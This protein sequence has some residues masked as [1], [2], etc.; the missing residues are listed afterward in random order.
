[1]ARIENNR[2]LHPTKRVIETWKSD[3]R[4]S[5]G[6]NTSTFISL[7][8]LGIPYDSHYRSRIVLPAG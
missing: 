1:M 4:T 5:D 7:L 8:D 2:L 6:P 3:F